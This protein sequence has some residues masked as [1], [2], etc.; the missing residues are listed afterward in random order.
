LRRAVYHALVRDYSEQV[1][2]N[3][4]HWDEIAPIHRDSAF[5]AE[6]LAELRAGGSRLH[7]LE[8]AEVGDVRGKSLLH[9]Q[10]HFGL[11]SLSWARLGATV[12]GIDFSVQAIAAAQGLASELGLTARFVVSDVYDLPSKLEGQFDIVF[13]SYGAITWLPDMERWARVAARFVKPGGFLYV[14][15][16]HPMFQV[17]DDAAGLTGPRLAYPY[18]ESEP[19]VRSE[20]DG[21]YA[22]LGAH[23]T[24]QLNF[25]FPHSLGEIVTSVIEAGLRLDFLHEFPYCTYP[26]LPFMEQHDDGLWYLTQGHGQVPLLFSL[27][28][29][30]P[31]MDR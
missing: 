24:N 5:Y 7:A 29:T 16:F 23:V 20:V 12:T 14:A 8:A 4:R 3:R 13:T 6:H 10:C 11:D 27:K 17:L 28:A 18:F 1:E 31:P 26:A 22:D 2:A 19:P 21:T 15:E 30:K 9:L 25:C